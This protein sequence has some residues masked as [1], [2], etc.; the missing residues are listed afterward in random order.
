MFVC[1]RHRLTL[2]SYNMLAS[3]GSPQSAD[4]LTR[5][6]DMSDAE[7][8]ENCPQP[9]PFNVP[10]YDAQ[11][12]SEFV[13]SAQRATE[14]D[15]KIGGSADI[16]VDSQKSTSQYDFGQTSVGADVSGGW[17]YPYSASGQHT[18]TS[19]TFSSTAA[20]SSIKITVTWDDIKAITITPGKW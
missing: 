8:K 3:T 11:G 1:Q 7:R 14:T 5:C 10:A 13:Q 12:Y 18:V 9:S 6:L 16:T 20:A 4:L 2:I 15:Y 17:F 19:E